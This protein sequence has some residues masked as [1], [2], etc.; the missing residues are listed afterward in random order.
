MDAAEVVKRVDQTKIS[1]RNSD[2]YKTI[3]TFGP[4]YLMSERHT[5]SN[6]SQVKSMKYLLSITNKKPQSGRKLFL[7]P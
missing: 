1:S 4:S 2:N 3:K 7:C 5:D 6:L